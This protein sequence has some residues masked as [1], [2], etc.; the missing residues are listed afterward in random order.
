MLRVGMWLQL[1]SCSLTSVFEAAIHS[2]EDCIFQSV[3]QFPPKFWTFLYQQLWHEI[4]GLWVLSSNSNIWEH[5]HVNIVYAF[6]AMFWGY[7]L[8]CIIFDPMQVSSETTLLCTWGSNQRH[9]LCMLYLLRQ[10]NLF[11]LD[12]ITY[13]LNIECACACSGPRAINWG[14]Q[15]LL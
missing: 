1:V 10:R 5:I 3:F 7:I 13:H 12:L 6:V 2:W 14:S 15:L 11:I 9:M 8:D 4:T